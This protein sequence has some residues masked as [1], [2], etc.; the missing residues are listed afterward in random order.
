M[1]FEKTPH[2]LPWSYA[3]KFTD[4]SAE[5]FGYDMLLM[6]HWNEQRDERRVEMMKRC[7]VPNSEEIIKDFEEK[8]DDNYFYQF[9]E[10]MWK[11][12]LLRKQ[13]KREHYPAQTPRIPAPPPRREPRRC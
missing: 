11:D 12:G 2:E 4:T 1:P 8:G 7:N 9:I 3:Q 13:K 5:D 10:L 6:A